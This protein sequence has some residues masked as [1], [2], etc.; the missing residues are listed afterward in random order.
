MKMQ[1][2]QS[3][4]IL[5]ALLATQGY[6]MDVPNREEEPASPKRAATIVMGILKRPD[7]FVCR[8]VRT[9]T[10]SS[11]IAAAETEHM[12]RFR[13]G[14]LNIT[15]ED[16]TVR[17]RRI[18]ELMNPRQEVFDLRAELAGT[19][20]AQIANYVSYRVGYPM[21]EVLEGDN[22]VYVYLVDKY[23]ALKNPHL[24]ELWERLRAPHADVVHLFRKGN[25]QLIEFEYHISSFAHLGTAILGDIGDIYYN[26]GKWLQ[27]SARSLWA[28]VH[29]R[30][31]N[32]RWNGWLWNV[33]QE[34][35]YGISL[36]VPNRE[37]LPASL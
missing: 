31:G 19:N 10:G 16:G 22:R 11:I 13:T 37:E 27:K 30:Q 7:H 9:M 12:A 25:W 14:T 21:D 6:S 33:L 5:G 15:L 28:H 2:T 29:V 18:G 8:D 35:A 23:D 1:K 26:E 36:D 4:M 20:R 17:Q 24:K 34:G 3:I 32:A